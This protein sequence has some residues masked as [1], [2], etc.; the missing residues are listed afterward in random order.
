MSQLNLYLE[1]APLHI[2]FCKKFL[3]GF[4][5]NLEIHSGR[6][7][8]LIFVSLEIHFEDQLKL[9]PEGKQYWALFCAKEIGILSSSGNASGFLN[10]IDFDLPKYSSRIIS[11]S[12]LWRS[13]NSPLNGVKSVFKQCHILL[14]IYVA[15]QCLSFQSGFCLLHF[16]AIVPFVLSWVAT[17]PCNPW[18]FT[19]SP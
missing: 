5:S 10:L 7:I 2:L 19:L 9:N 13:R 8:Y 18:H 15:A 1:G 6:T 14:K 4:S 11:L 12:I 17:N 16:F 3:G